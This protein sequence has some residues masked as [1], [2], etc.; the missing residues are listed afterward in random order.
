[1][2]LRFTSAA[3]AFCFALAAPIS[4]YA[5][6]GGSAAVYEQTRDVRHVAHADLSPNA[7][8]LAPASAMISAGRVKETDGLSRNLDDCIYGCIDN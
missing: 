2:R 8:A 3:L 1:M 7:T 4:A 6:G 5:F